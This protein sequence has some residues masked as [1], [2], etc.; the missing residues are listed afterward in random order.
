MQTRGVHGYLHNLF[1]TED[2]CGSHR[3]VPSGDG[4]TVTSAI[5]TE[6]QTKRLSLREVLLAIRCFKI[7]YPKLTPRGRELC[8]Q[9]TASASDE[10]SLGGWLKHAS[11]TGRARGVGSVLNGHTSFSSRSDVICE[12]G[13]AGPVTVC[14]VR[15][16]NLH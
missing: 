8:K 2:G 3:P 1:P 7:S 4:S 14:D 9:D 10:S 11:Q 6:Q 5:T 16:V 13:G 12:A 15:D